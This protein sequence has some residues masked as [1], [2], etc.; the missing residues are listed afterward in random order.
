MDAYSKLTELVHQGLD[1][2]LVLAPPRSGSTMLEKVLSASNTFDK[3]IHEPFIDYGYRGIEEARC[4]EQLLSEIEGSDILIKD[5]AHFLTNK[6]VFERFVSLIDKPIV[7]N[8]RNPL[9][10]AESRI[11]VMLKST[12]IK[13]RT[14]TQTWLLD[15]LAKNHSNWETISEVEKSRLVGRQDFSI[16]NLKLQTGLLNY[17]AK[18]KGESDWEQ[19]VSNASA[20]Q[21]Y[22]HLGDFLSSNPKRFSLSGFGWGAV[23]EQ[24][25]H[26]D[27]I[28]KPY[29]II[30]NTDFR[31]NPEYFSKAICESWNIDYNE[32]MLNWDEISIGEKQCRAQDKVWY[33]SI[34]NSS[35]VKPPTEPVPP[36]KAFPEFIQNYLNDVA[37]PIY[38]K[39]MESKLS[40]KVKVR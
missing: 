11:K 4:Y 10:C 15:Y 5:M 16:A 22:S 18:T 13:P 39:A 38:E 32:S 27:K 33:E 30:N 25:A 21:T 36:I 6:A 8:L 40:V 23:G 35:S 9:L 24:L 29:L 28:N 12:A 19:L 37:I 26:L 20:E 7:Y 1:I 3:A 17:Y 34:I 2:R 31:N 14:S